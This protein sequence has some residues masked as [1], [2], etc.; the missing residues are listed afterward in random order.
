MKWSFF[1]TLACVLAALTPAVPAQ[2]SKVPAS[3]VEILSLD[4]CLQ[5]ALVNNHRHKISEFGIAIAEAQ[6]RQALSGYW[7]QVNLKAGIQRSDQPISYLIP[8][9]GIGIPAQQ[10]PIPGGAALVTIPANAFG[11]GFPPGNVQLPVAYPGQMIQTPA[12]AFSLPQQNWKIADRDLASGN[13]NVSW[14][15]F[16]GGLRKGLREQ[17]GAGLSAATAETK[18]TDLEVAEAVSRF[19]WAA[20]LAR[21]LKEVGEDT[22]AGLDITLQMT[23]VHVKSGTGKT[24]R[25]DYLYNQVVVESARA[26]VAELEKN[27]KLAEAAL[28]N[29]IGK[30]W[31]VSIQPKD[32][33]L[34]SVPALTALDTLV[35]DCYRF[36]PDW[37]ELQA[38]L[39]AANGALK[40][41]RSDYFPKLGLKGDLHSFWNGGFNSGLST[42]QNR[43]GWTV[44]AGVE[45]PIFNGLLTEGQV[46]EAILRVRQLKEKQ[47]LLQ[48]GLG[49]QIK[50]I[51][52]ELNA[53]AKTLQAST[54]AMRSATQNRELNMSAYESDMTEAD[55]VIQ[56]QVIA[57]LATAQYRKSQYDEIALLSRLGTVVGHQVANLVFGT[58]GS[59]SKN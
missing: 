23:D 17:A 55:K 1:C 59:G 37:A 13:L 12:Q 8:A 2:E 30:A 33:Q 47:L 45:V 19:Y 7:P 32:T 26:T 6:H 14:L 53:A 28:A 50:G 25:S 44:G 34:P 41:K 20:V 9:Q 48:D 52:I 58:A 11:P 39:V 51:V 56:A 54:T 5:Q 16:D 40:S 22:L 36:N 10:I 24:N 46:S 4:Q 18:R 43:F 27:Q 21:Q 29:T 49:L 3:S 42:S 31:Q 57:A 35:A 15:L 38:G